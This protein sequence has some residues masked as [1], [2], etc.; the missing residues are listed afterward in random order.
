[1]GTN[2]TPFLSYPE[3]STDEIDIYDDAWGF[4][5]QFHDVIDLLRQVKPVPGK[6]LTDRLIK[7]VRSKH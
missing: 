4:Y 1:M 6:K 5:P 7:R 2:F 3:I